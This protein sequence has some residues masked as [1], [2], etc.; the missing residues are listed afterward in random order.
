MVMAV[1]IMDKVQQ[2]RGP[3]TVVV[4]VVGVEN[5]SGREGKK[6][7]GEGKRRKSGEGGYLQF[8]IG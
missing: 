6:G 7:S 4:M 1:E 3:S 8:E 5:Q 2:C